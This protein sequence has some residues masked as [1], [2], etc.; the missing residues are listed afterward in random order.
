ML[1]HTRH[2]LDFQESSIIFLFDSILR[3]TN[4]R[5]VLGR[6]D[7]H[8]FRDGSVALWL[9]AHVVEDL[10]LHLVGR[11]VVLRGKFYWCSIGVLFLFYRVERPLCREVLSCAIW[12]LWNMT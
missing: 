5:H 3:E 12:Q 10:H 7:L 4:L 2:V 11:V 1:I 6:V 9:L 8:R